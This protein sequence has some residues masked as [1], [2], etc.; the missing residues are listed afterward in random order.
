[1][2]LANVRTLEE[3]TAESMAQ[4]SF[5]LVM[6][7]IAAGVSL[8]AGRRR[9]LRRHRLHHGAAGT[10]GRAFAW[11][12]ARSRAT[13][14]GLFVRHGLLL[15]GLGIGLGVVAAAALSR[16]MASMLFGV[17]ATDPLTYVV[18]STGLAGVAVLA[19]YL[20]SRRAARVD[21]VVALRGT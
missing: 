1:M 8:L 12:S 9:D 19:G 13:S 5:A 16:L 17:S 11:P 3:I 10:R 21:P 20:P 14:R 18:M 7:A 6:L 15:A 2:P 4:T